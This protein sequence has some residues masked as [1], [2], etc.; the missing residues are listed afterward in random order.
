MQNAPRTTHDSTDYALRTN[1]CGH[2][3]WDLWPPP[4]T[5]VLW[6]Q[7]A[8]CLHTDGVVQGYRLMRTEELPMQGALG[9]GF[10]PAAVTERAV[11]VLRFL[12]ENCTR[13]ARS[14]WRA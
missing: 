14:R 3:L 9:E 6:L 2:R 8:L 10:S 4:L 11:S 1:A 7:V 5:R 12:R 13:E